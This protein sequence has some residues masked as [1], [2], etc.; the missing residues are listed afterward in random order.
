MILSRWFASPNIS[1]GL[2]EVLFSKLPGVASP[3]DIRTPDAP[4]ATAEIDRSRGVTD[5]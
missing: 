2:M 1:V 4:D 3:Q 5:P